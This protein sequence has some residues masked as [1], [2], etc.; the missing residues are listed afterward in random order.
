[1]NL[2]CSRGFIPTVV[3]TDPQSAFR[4]LVGQFP[5]VVID[6]GG[7]GDYVSKVDAKIR[8]IKE[9]YRSV[10]AGLKWKLPPTLVKDLVAYAVSRIN[11]RITTAI[12]LNVSPRVLFTGMRINYKKELEIAFGDYVEVYDGT[13]NMS[14]SRSVPCIALYPCCNAT[15]SWE[16]MS[17]KSKT[18]VRHSQWKL[19]VMTQ[20]VIDTMN[21]FDEEPVAVVAEPAINVGTPTPT[22]TIV[23]QVPESTVQV[24]VDTG[25]IEPE[26]GEETP[27]VEQVPDATEQCQEQELQL[28]EVVAEEDDPEMPALVAQDPAEVSQ[29][30]RLMRMKTKTRKILL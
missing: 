1:L 23:E 18:R 16:F 13:D 6:I 24:Q 28:P 25:G 2:L 5:E 11:I 17:L 20:A 12:N 21:A 10:K 8:R 4:A 27:G 3:H 15:G 19:M 14:K 9:L 7:A 30:M 26:R 22:T 29:M